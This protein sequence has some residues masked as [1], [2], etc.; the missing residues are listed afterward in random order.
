MDGICHV[1]LI[2]I[3]FPIYRMDVGYTTMCAMDGMPYAVSLNYNQ[4]T[5]W[6]SRTY[7]MA[8]YCIPVYVQYLNKLFDNNDRQ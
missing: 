5:I 6:M 3:L 7:C 2:K 4:S 1:L 8:R